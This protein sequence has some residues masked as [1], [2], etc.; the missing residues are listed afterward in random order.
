MNAGRN[1]PSQ[2]RDHN[3]GGGLLALGAGVL[4]L[5]LLAA[6]PPHAAI[7]E[8]CRLTFG[9]TPVEVGGDVV[10]LRVIPSE[11]LTGPVELAFEEGSGLQGR[12]TTEG[13]LV[14]EVNPA[15]AQEGRWEVTLTDVAG[16]VCTGSL[17]VDA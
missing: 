13:P 12:L 15:N 14:L 3:V 2:S 9:P 11:E 7:A 6:A 1:T 16:T 5:S 10:D 4:L 17:T 8:D